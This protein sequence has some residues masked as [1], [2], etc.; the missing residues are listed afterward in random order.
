MYVGDRF[1]TSRHDLPM[2]PFSHRWLART[3]SIWIC[4]NLP[5]KIWKTVIQFFERST[6][7]AQPQFSRATLMFNEQKVDIAPFMEHILHNALADSL[8]DTVPHES[9]AENIINTN[10]NAQPHSKATP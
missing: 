8:A 4:H 7:L 10:T 5:S 2:N 6:T 1:S 3:G 9:G